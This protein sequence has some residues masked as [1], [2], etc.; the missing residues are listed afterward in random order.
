MRLKDVDKMMSGRRETG[1]IQKKFFPN[2]SV[3]V[4]ILMCYSQN[5]KNLFTVSSEK[6]TTTSVC[7]LVIK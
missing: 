7:M 3:I 1:C 2:P 6:F 5:K 4:L